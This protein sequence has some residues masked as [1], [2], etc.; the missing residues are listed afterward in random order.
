MEKVFV[1]LK[2]KEAAISKHK[3]L[4]LLKIKALKAD[5]KTLVLFLKK[6]IKKKEDIPKHSQQNSKSIQLFEK[7]KKSIL[8]IKKFKC[9][10]NLSFCKKEKV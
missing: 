1:I 4:I 9:S 8:S 6:F 10:K 2:Y 5:L 7:T 3:S